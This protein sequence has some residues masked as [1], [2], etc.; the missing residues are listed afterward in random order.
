MYSFGL[1]N[2]NSHPGNF[3]NL[4]PNGGMQV[5]SALPKKKRKKVTAQG[6]RSEAKKKRKAALKAS[7]V[8]VLCLFGLLFLRLALTHNH[9]HCRN[10]ESGPSPG[11]YLYAEKKRLLAAYFYIKPTCDKDC[12]L[13]VRS[14]CLSSPLFAHK[15]CVA[16]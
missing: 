1:G 13:V 4:S 5:Q 10:G 16:T 9:I 8:Y 6:L 12:L 11:P 15:V 7:K 14:F 2:E 3:L